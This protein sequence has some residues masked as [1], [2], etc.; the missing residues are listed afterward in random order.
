VESLERFAQYQNIIEEFTS[1]TLLGIRSDM[2]RL[3]TAALLRD[4]S[5]GRYS[6]PVL[7]RKYSEAAVH[8]ALLFCHEELFE[9][10]LEAPLEKLEGDLRDWFASIP[11]PPAEVATRWLETEFFR[12]LVPQGT[13]TY[14]RD[15]LFSNL[16]VVLVLV[17]AKRSAA[18][19]VP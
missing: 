12:L 10:I 19:T 1:R 15:L 8:Q 6:E 16:R 7:E 3:V 5:T 14:L 9:K 4:V 17:A 18:E 13:P 11:A 2:G